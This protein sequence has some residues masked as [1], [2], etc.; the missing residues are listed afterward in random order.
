MVVLDTD[1][2][3]FCGRGRTVIGKKPEMGR[4]GITLP[5]YS[6]MILKEKI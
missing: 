6:G 4:L 2:V 3:D 5:A 1:S